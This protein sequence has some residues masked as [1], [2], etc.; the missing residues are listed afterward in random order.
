MTQN[1]DNDLV[2]NE[3][4]VSEGIIQN[5]FENLLEERLGKIWPIWDE[6][7]ILRGTLFGKLYKLRNSV[8]RINASTIRNMIP[9]RYVKNMNAFKDILNLASDNN[10]DVLVYIPPIRNDVKLPY[11]IKD[12]NNFKKEIHDITKEYDVNFFSLENLVPPN[13]W[14]KKFST[15]LK[16]VKEI[17]FMHFQAKGHQLLAEAL[18]IEIIKN[19]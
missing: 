4:K 17:D 19:K 5:N 6:R 13:F 3:F 10:L 15:N 1:I 16:K 14:G 12:Y 11:N 9:E 2:G 18:F 8:F 7:E